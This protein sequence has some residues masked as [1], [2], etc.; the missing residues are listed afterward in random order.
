[1]SNNL[2]KKILIVEDEPIL[3]QA[4][5]DALL[6]EGC[7][8]NSA[9]NGN[10]GIE[11]FRKYQHEVVLT[12]MV[13]PGIGG[14]QL[15]EEI[16]NY[17]PSTAVF[18]FTAFGSVDIAVKAM[19]LGAIDFIPKPFRISELVE[20]IR[21]ETENRTIDPE[22]F[23]PKVS[24]SKNCRI[25][26]FIGNSP[27]MHKI[28][29]LILTFAPSDANILLRGESGTGKE[30]AA[31][32]IHY[33][34]KRS[35]HPFIK[36]GCATLTE[37]LLE[38]ELFGHEKGAFTGAMQRKIGRFELAHRGTILL[39]EI[40]DI[41]ETVQMKLLRVLQEREFERVGGTETLKVD[42]RIV[43]ASLH[44]LHRLVEIGKFREDLFYRINTITIDLPSLSSREGDLK[45]L[46][47][48]FCNLHAERTGKPVIGIQKDA[49][50]L[51]ESYAWPGNVR[52]LKNVVERAV[53]ITQGH[54][55][56]ANDLP[57]YMQSPSARYANNNVVSNRNNNQNDIQPLSSVVKES[58]RKHILLVLELTS[59]N[60]TK[61]ARI[62]AISRKT[63]WE[64]MRQYSI[65]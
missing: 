54:L 56:T 63:L 38:S 18:A 57:D 24:K 33:N 55:I 14:M 62:L 20:K 34:S 11:L 52:E 29:D 21:R 60:R 48:H 53:L 27:Q 2:C 49:L 12:D 42:V 10:E 37:T 45:V 7:E 58:E 28:Y 8:V 1:M 36:V 59:N 65:Q 13:M 25:D 9:D 41:S 51:F 22:S 32:A 50:K 15:I 6:E 61:A 16:M 35:D 31:S 40:G 3:R 30:L 39:D 17:K 46:A 43:S 23:P 44:D 19:K 26:G 47:E 5:Q 64:K 4:L